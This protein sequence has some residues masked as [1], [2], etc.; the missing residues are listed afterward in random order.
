MI[1]IH[2]KSWGYEKWLVNSELYC[3]KI[4]CVN[5]GKMCSV[6]YHELKDETFYVLKGDVCF[7]K[8]N[9]VFVL[10]EGETIHI[11]TDTPHCFGG[12]GDAEIIE[13]STQHFDTDSIRIT[14]SGRSFDGMNLN[15]FEESIKN[16]LLDN[17]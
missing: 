7:M 2:E 6:H 1:E 5:N 14:K 16:G 11:P 15:S 4:L 10:S 8:N 12:V 9:A 13:I 3:G 17:R